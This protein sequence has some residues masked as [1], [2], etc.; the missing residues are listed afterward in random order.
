[1]SNT[2]VTTYVDQLIPIIFG[3]YSLSLIIIGSIFNTLTMLILCR[4]NFRNINERPTIHYMR[5]IAIID[6][7]ILYGWNLNRFTLNIYGFTIRT[8]TIG[9]C[10]INL[11]FNYSLLQISAWLRIFICLD[12]YFAL[13]RL[14]RTWFSRSKS[15]LIIIASIISFF[16]LLN[17]HL[18]IFGCH[19]NSNGTIN[20]NSA[21]YAITPLWDN[22]QLVL[23]NFI[24]ILFII[25]LYTAVI[26]HLIRRHQQRI[27][28][29][30]RIQHRSISIT[31]VITTFLFLSMTA[32]SNI[33]YAFFYSTVSSIVINIFAVLVY[34]YHVLSFPLYLF[35]W[36]E[37]RQEFIKMILCRSSL[38]RIQPT[39][40]PTLSHR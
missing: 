28:Q 12:R 18:L 4:G 32:P 39:L 1:M 3:Y 23:Y 15:T 2:T 33:I 16:V 26:Y 25:I 37:F 20:P 7:L 14:H 38:R 22:V 29:N 10:K 11:F 17:L 21:L 30:S 19:Y 13:S 9:S 35:T 34:T 8:M 36:N 40:A 31:L 24:P 27:I 6:I 5:A